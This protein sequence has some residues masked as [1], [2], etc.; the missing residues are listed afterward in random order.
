MSASDARASLRIVV[1]LGNPGPEYAT[2][3]HNLGFLVAD[4]IA[5][6]ERVGLSQKFRGLYARFGVDEAT[7][8][9]VKPQTYM[10]CSGECVRAL[11]DFFKFELGPMSER[12]IVVHDDLDLPFGTVRVKPGGGHAGH[13]GLRSLV[14]HLGTQEFARVRMGIGRPARGDPADY[15]LSDFAASERPFVP[16]LV[17]KGQEAVELWLRRGLQAA[18]NAVN[19][20]NAGP[21]GSPRTEPGGAREGNPN[22]AQS[23]ARDP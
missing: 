15:V 23:K 16:D 19:P 20:T 10:N 22:G 12:L 8:V 14:Q 3:R 1:G 17:A 2:T 21:K 11:C 18:M 6:G 13:N 5:G 9:L 7:V 4:R